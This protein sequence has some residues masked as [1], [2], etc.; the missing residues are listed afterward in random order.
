MTSDI[1]S[2]PTAARWLYGLAPSDF[3]AARKRLVTALR[4][5]GLTELAKEVALLRRPTVR[6][7]EM[8]RVLRVAGDGVESML[9]AA[10]ALRAGHRA[11]LDGEPVDLG[12][13][14]RDHRAAASAVADQAERDQAEIQALLEAASLDESLHQAL[15]EASFATEPEPQAG[16]DLLSAHPDA[17]VSSLSEAR[18][19]R[20]AAAHPS[21]APVEPDPTDDL[22]TSPT[23][24]LAPVTAETFTPSTPPV[25]EATADRART[26]AG[27]E[28]AQLEGASK[29]HE[30][31]LRRMEAAART[32]SKAKERVEAAET[33]L[34]A[35]RG[36][37]AEATA[38]LEAAAAAE[39]RAQARLEAAQGPGDPASP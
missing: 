17:T 19:R 14:R 16:F 27:D 38:R 3:I 13:L 2:L 28:G 12:R 25:S 8:N 18:A 9:G 32:V 10:R 20:R 30:L 4:A 36:Q 6:A 7:A 24:D 29:S 26:K 15:R 1:D 34:A 21:D 5:T 23:P 37:L 35:A 33:R 22:G 11:A 31:A 39:Q